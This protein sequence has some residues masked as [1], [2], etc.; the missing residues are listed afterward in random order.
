MKL[1]TRSSKSRPPARPQLR[2][3]NPLSN[4][5]ALCHLD[6]IFGPRISSEFHPSDFG[7]SPLRSA[8]K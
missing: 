4:L 6:A 1:S 5:R 2:L 8:T 7:F 3:A